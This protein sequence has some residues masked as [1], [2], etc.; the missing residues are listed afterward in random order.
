MLG[1]SASR[2]ATSSHVQKRRLVRA[3]LLAEL[4]EVPT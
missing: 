2:I 1:S 4:N 3:F